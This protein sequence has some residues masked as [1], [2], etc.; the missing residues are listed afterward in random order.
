MHGYL[1]FLRRR[2]RDLEENLDKYLLALKKLAERYGGRAYLFGSVLSGEAIA[3]SDV[4]VLIEV[5][6]DVD[7]LRV[8]H[9][10]RRLVPNTLVEIHVLNASDAELFKR[11]VKRIKQL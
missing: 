4:D 6:D 10:A 5:P 9:E 3:A 1:E 7:R 8:L 11:L 2:R